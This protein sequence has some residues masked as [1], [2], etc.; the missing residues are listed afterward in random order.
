VN[1]ATCH[2]PGSASGSLDLRLQTPMAST[3]LCGA[4]AKGALGVTGGSI[5]TPGLPAQSV[6]SRRLHRTDWP[7]MPP[8][9]IQL[10][11]STGTALVDDWI[12]TAAQCAGARTD[13]GG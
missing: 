4:A 6:L 11:D 2:H 1:C 3:G 12:T 13:G 7:R 10:F 9:E 5:L 8:V